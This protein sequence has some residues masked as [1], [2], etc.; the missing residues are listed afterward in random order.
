MSWT[1][2]DVMSLKAEG[3]GIEEEHY[4]EIDE[5]DLGDEEHIE[6]IIEDPEGKIYEE[7]LMV[8]SLTPDL[9][10]AL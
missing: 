9:T 3:I 6:Y 5:N 4:A 7:E 1:E 8:G 2:I 10:L